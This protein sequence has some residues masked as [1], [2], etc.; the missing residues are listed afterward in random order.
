MN[1]QAELRLSA[2]EHAQLRALASRRKTSQGLALRVRIVLACA[3]HVD[4]GEIARREGV[5]VQT[6]AKWRARFVAGRIGGLQDA[7]RSGA[8]RTVDAACVQ[9][10]IAR[11]LHALPPGGGRWSTRGM[12]QACGLSQATVSR[13]WR[14]HGLQPQR[15]QNT[16]TRAMARDELLTR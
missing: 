9:A 10:V 8:P 15:P 7:P 6:V 12:A 5:S 2:S 16:Q 1:P 14:A 13:I 3:Q 4:L 11:T